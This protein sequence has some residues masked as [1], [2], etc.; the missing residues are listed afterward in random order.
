MSHLY[1]VRHGQTTSNEIQALDTALP[2]ADLTELGRE[3]AAS[4]GRILSERSGSLHVLSSQAARAQQTAAQLAVNFAGSGG[5]LLSSG[6]GSVFSSRFTGVDLTPFSDATALSLA[7]DYGNELAMI[8]GVSEIPAGEYE[9]KNDHDSHVAY[10]KILGAWMTGDV[11]MPV[12]G[13]STG[14][15]ILQAYIP[16][17]L[18]LM[19]A[20]KVEEHAAPMG[21]VASDSAEIALVS[22]GAVI[23][24]VARYLGAIDPEFAFRGYLQNSHFIQLEIPQNLEDLTASIAEDFATGQGAFSVLEWGEHGRPL[25]Q[26]K[27]QG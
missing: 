18:A 24:L 12:P 7:G 23:R 17:L 5:S 8:H 13:G 22:H 2:G 15:Q 27:L 19:A 16:Q 1:L 11:E 20:V 25:L 3:Q 26:T 6:P 14:S 4:A 21:S 10:H 9:M